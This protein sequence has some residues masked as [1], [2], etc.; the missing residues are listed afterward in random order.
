MSFDYGSDG[1]YILFSFQFCFDPSET[2]YFAFSYPF[3]NEESLRKSEQM[4]F[5][6]QE[7]SSIYF[8]REVL[9]HSIEGR[10]VELL[11][12]TGTTRITEKREDKIEG[13]FPLSQERPHVFEK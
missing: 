13:L 7:S 9:Y 4:T 2:A 12:L 10:E 11:T 8:Q 1:F 5:K 6:Y 3:S